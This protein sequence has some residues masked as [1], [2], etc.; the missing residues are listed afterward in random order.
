MFNGPF[1]FSFYFCPFPPLQV[2]LFVMHDGQ[3]YPFLSKDKDLHLHTT[4][5]T[6]TKDGRK[7]AS[8]E[9]LHTSLGAF[10]KYFWPL[11]LLPFVNTH[12]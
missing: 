4:I 6:L 1:P 10:G 7:V 2:G 3:H 12:E 5:T 9:F 11:D 8:L